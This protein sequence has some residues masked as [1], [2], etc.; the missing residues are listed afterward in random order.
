MD[1]RLLSSAKQFHPVHRSLA[2]LPVINLRCLQRIHPSSDID[3]ENDSFYPAS[4]LILNNYWIVNSRSV[5]LNTFGAYVKN[6]P[7]N[8]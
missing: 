8:R 4:D 2:H 1:K 6:S 7:P 3:H 5:Q